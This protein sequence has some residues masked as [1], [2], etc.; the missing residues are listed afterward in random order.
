[1]EGPN[2]Y[3][4]V[5][6]TDKDGV[7]T[8]N[9][10]PW[11]TYE[12]KETK[13]PQ[14]YKL[15]KEIQ[16]ITIG[17]STVEKQQNITIIDGKELGSLVITKEG[18]DKEKLAGATFEITGPNDFNKTVVTGKD[19]TVSVNGLAWGSYEV[20]EIKAPQGYNLDKTP[21]T[22]E[23]NSSNVKSIQNLIFKDSKKTGTLNITKIGNDGAKLSGAE[24]TVEG[25]N[26]YKQI[27]TTDKAGVATLNNI[28]WGTYTVRE[29][30]A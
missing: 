26:G 10:I 14:G 5:V 19:G 21:Q 7:A 28:P 29:T 24:F 6:T 16:T 22:I 8:L 20:K 17:A 13:A 27:V 12:I 11:G 30:K 9:N 23:I 3:K 25:P 15:N 1:V 18:P 4:Q 2:G